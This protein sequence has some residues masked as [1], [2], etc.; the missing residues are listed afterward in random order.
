[1]IDVAGCAEDDGF[2]GEDS[3]RESPEAGKGAGDVPGKDDAGTERE[4]PGQSG[5]EA[6]GAIGGFL[7]K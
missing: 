2:H 3:I 5:F 1:M 7:F 4:N 6:R